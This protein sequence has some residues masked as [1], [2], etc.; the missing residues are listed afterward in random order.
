M[1]LMIAL[2]VALVVAVPGKKAQGGKADV[3]VTTFALYDIARHLL[4]KGA[5]VQMLIPFGQN[6]HTFEPTPQDMI[7]VQ[8]S[9]LFLYSGAGL[10]PWAVPFES[11]GNAVDMSTYVR[12]HE[13]GHADH[14]HEAGTHSAHTFD[15]HYWLDTDNMVA[16]VRGMEKRFAAAF[17]ALDARGMHERAAAYIGRLETLDALYRK[18]LGH[19]RL[20]TIVV[21]HNAFGYLAE[22]YGFHVDAITGL[23]PDMMPDAKTMMH[24]SDLVREKG[25]GTLFYEAF[26]SDKL[27]ASLAAETGV[28]VDVLQPL[29][30]ITADEIGVD[31]FRLMNVNLLKLHD[32]MECQ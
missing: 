25:I 5:E 4:G 20:D 31:Y 21:S 27:A 32:A 8:K 23:S 15:P 24:L 17:P 6:V 14:D 3:V 30:N 11:F 18:R 2:T 28:R 19:C 26:V 1:V 12:L 7:R 13:A 9:R 22:R 29:A 16:L 10:E